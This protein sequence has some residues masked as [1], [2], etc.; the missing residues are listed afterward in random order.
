VSPAD[1]PRLRTLHDV[2]A[3]LERELFFQVARQDEGISSA[4]RVA[5]EFTYWKNAAS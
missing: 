3:P 5:P 4:E 2:E 1:A